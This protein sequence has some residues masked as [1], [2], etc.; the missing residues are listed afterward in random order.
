MLD[1]AP[2][3]EEITRQINAGDW[4]AYLG[5]DQARENSWQALRVGKI[6]IVYPPPSPEDAPVISLHPKELQV[7]QG[8]GSGLSLIQIAYRHQVT[9]KT[10][11]NRL[12]RIQIKFN[13]HTREELVAKATALNYIKPDLDSIFD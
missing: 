1:F 5:Y 8:L 3:P 2:R 11:Q 4:Q 6:V 10:V 13:A 9:V 12:Y 7:L